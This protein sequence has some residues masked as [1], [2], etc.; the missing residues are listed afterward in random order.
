MYIGLVITI[1]YP[2]FINDK[3][4]CKTNLPKHFQERKSA[5]KFI[6]IG[7]LKFRL[8]LFFIVRTRKKDGIFELCHKVK[9]EDIKRK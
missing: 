3:E 1:Q 8:L 5:Q 6:K 2:Q 9:T 7:I 4:N